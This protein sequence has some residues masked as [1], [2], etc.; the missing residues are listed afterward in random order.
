MNTEEEIELI[1]NGHIKEY[2]GII[3]CVD[4]K[5]YKNLTIGKQYECIPFGYNISFGGLDGLNGAK[6][7]YYQIVNDGNEQHNYYKERFITLEQH[8]E[9]QLNKIL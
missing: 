8:R 3:I 7:L 6:E 1:K 5:G 2:E 9:Q 4:N